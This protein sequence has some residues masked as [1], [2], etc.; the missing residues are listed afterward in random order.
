MADTGAPWNIPYVAGTDLVRDWPTDSQELADA[1]ADGLDAAGNAGI[2]SNVVTAASSSNFTTTSTS[3]VDV[4]GVTVNIT[5]GAATSKVLVFIG[6][7]FF[8][9]NSNGINSFVSITDGSNNV[10]STVRAEPDN[11][12]RNHIPPSTFA[13]DTPGS[14]GPHTYKM[15]LR[16][17]AT[18]TARVDS[19]RVIAIEVAA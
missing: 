16:T 14:V 4:T 9:N 12:N 17:G 10:L 5:L 3:D 15:R 19:G 18:G 1:I 6:G 2:G 8:N 11:G 7:L 13:L